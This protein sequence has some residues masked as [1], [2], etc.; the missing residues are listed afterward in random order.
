MQ[1]YEVRRMKI[2]FSWATISLIVRSIWTPKKRPTV[3]LLLP[4]VKPTQHVSVPQCAVYLSSIWEGTVKGSFADQ[5][6]SLYIVIGTQ[7]HS[8]LFSPQRRLS[9]KSDHQSKDRRRYHRFVKKLS[10]H[11]SVSRCAFDLISIVSVSR[12]LIVP[13]FWKAKG[14]KCFWCP[15]S[16]GYV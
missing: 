2:A 4:I 5:F 10:Q 3:P 16:S 8:S 9:A 1:C 11:V 7:E 12:V 6:S 15:F 14:Q 13:G